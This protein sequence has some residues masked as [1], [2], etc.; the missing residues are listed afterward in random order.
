MKIVC[1]ILNC[2]IAIF[3]A[4][5]ILES[6]LVTCAETETETLLSDSTSLSTIEIREKYAPVFILD[7]V[8]I[9]ISRDKCFYVTRNRKFYGK[10]PE[11]NYAIEILKRR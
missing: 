10:Y 1:I 8:T 2:I 4:K 7:S 3:I 6:S 5:I 11:D 9:V